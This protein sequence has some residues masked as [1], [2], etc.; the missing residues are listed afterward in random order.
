M[1]KKVLWDKRGS[2]WEEQ[3]VLMI[4]V[5]VGLIVTIIVSTF[6]IVNGVE[7]GKE[8]FCYWSVLSRVEQ[9]FYTKLFASE[10]IPNPCYTKE[11][12]I[13]S[14]VVGVLVEEVEKCAKMLSPA[15]N[16]ENKEFKTDAFQEKC[17]VCAVLR[18]EKELV[19]S[20]LNNQKIVN[21]LIAQD[22]FNFLVEHNL[23]IP[24]EKEGLLLTP[25][26]SEE[27][28]KNFKPRKIGDKEYY[29]FAVVYAEMDFSELAN[30]YSEGLMHSEIVKGLG[31]LVG[32]TGE[33]TKRS[34]KKPSYLYVSPY[35]EQIW[36]KCYT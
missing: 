11:V 2:M 29:D 5:M 20:E 12:I 4:L 23:Y 14:N 10:I 8:R 33:D 6:I 26:S 17:H 18:I 15:L 31:M 34:S 28:F 16:P 25:Y 35:N 13:D 9:P 27:A 7:A 21:S 3:P 22:S 36:R 19:N 30:Y 1:L 24:S 32:G